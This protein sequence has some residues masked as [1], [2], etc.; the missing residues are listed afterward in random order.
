MSKTS[1]GEDVPSSALD[2]FLTSMTFAS[3][4]CEC[5][6]CD[7]CCTSTVPPDIALAIREHKRAR[8]MSEFVPGMISSGGL[9]SNAN[10]FSS[11]KQG[12]QNQERSLVSREMGVS[13]WSL[14][15]P[16]GAPPLIEYGNSDRIV[17]V[18]EMA[19]D[20]NLVSIG[21]G[22]FGSSDEERD[23]KPMCWEE[24]KAYLVP[25]NGGKTLGWI[26][27]QENECGKE[28]KD[29]GDDTPAIKYTKTEQV[30]IFTIKLANKSAGGDETGDAVSENMTDWV[31][32]VT[33]M[34]QKNLPSKSIAGHVQCNR[35]D[36]DEIGSTDGSKSTQNDSLSIPL[37]K[38][39]ERDI[40]SLSST[41]SGRIHDYRQAIPLGKEDCLLIQEILS[42]QL[43]GKVL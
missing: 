28:E 40:G 30:V 4:N 23:R 11:W 14:T 21:R 7:E 13:L 36:D 35:T 15:I 39:D 19:K 34:F 24:G 22:I 20:A 41:R 16:R 2:P 5:G 33:T 10:N 43:D 8:K 26:Y 9:F 18:K 25:S 29:S 32:K 6:G 1:E 12:F 31:R 38:S 17:F 42:D 27:Q 37:E 3:F